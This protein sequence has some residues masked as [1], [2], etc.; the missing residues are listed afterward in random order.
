MTTKQ[1][2]ICAT[3]DQ[4]LIR[5]CL[6]HG[7]LPRCLNTTIQTATVRQQEEE[8]KKQCPPEQ[9]KIGIGK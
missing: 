4:R 8:R 1:C 2:P 7:V 9:L 6:L 3:S 5:S